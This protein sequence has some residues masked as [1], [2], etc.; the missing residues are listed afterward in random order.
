MNLC[1]GVPLLIIIATFLLLI[2]GAKPWEAPKDNSQRWGRSVLT[3][4]ATAIIVICGL[5]L[6]GLSQSTGNCQK[7]IQNLKISSWACIGI[8]VFV[9]A[10][11]GNYVGYRQIIWLQSVRK[12]G[13]PP[14]K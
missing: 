3:G 8:P 5:A 1:Q 9:V 7:D 4:I 10:T 12:K 6:M 13:N 11:I 14:K 2:F